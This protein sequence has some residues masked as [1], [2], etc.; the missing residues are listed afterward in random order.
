MPDNNFEQQAR[1]MMNG[2]EIK[3][4]PEIWQNVRNAIQEPKR[5]RRFALWWWL[6]PLGLLGGG[7]AYYTFNIA[8]KNAQES[9]SINT[10]NQTNTDKKA[11]HPEEPNKQQT[12]T[13]KGKRKGNIDKPFFLSNN[14]NNNQKRSKTIKKLSGNIHKE[15]E[16]IQI[17]FD[18][19]IAEANKK[20]GLPDITIPV[21]IIGRNSHVNDSTISLQDEL[22]LLPKDSLNSRSSYQNSMQSAKA[23]RPNSV[24]NDKPDSTHTNNVKMRNGWKWGILA[25]VGT[26]TRKSSLFSTADFEKSLNDPTSPNSNGNGSSGVGLPQSNGF[27]YNNVIR[28]GFAFGLGIVLQKKL[29]KSIDFFADVAYY[30]QSFN[31]TTETYKD[32]IVLNNSF[33]TFTG[34][35]KA[36]QSFHFASLYAGINWHFINTKHLQFGV[37]AGVDNLLLLS[38]KQKYNGV[39]NGNLSSA[40]AMRISNSISTSKYYY[41]YQPSLFTGIL[42]NIQTGDRQLQFVPFVRSSF[43]PFDKN[44]TSN[45]NHLFSAGLRAV[46]FFR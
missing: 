18:E 19:N 17:T 36:T 25:E 22:N 10:V 33:T 2:F 43:R 21:P 37:S 39:N 30:Y 29:N 7:I 11:D 1:D 32:S 5:K 20:R 34:S 26:A 24:G 15:K 42:I 4:K 16:T 46:Y 35:Y 45:N 40:D 9:V 6:L 14:N 28:N 8:Y 44:T 27:Y 23:T 41:K 12:D 38:A 13:K 31:I 3:P